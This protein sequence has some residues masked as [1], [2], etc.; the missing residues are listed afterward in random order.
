MLQRRGTGGHL[1]NHIITQ[2]CSFGF[3][4]DDQETVNRVDDGSFYI[5]NSI[6][7]GNGRD[8]ENDADGIDEEAIF[9]TAAWDNQVVDPLLVDPL[10]RVN[11][12]FRLQAGSPAASGNGATPPN[13]GFFD[14]SATCIGA[15]CGQTEWYEGWT[16]HASS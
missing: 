14:T 15:V 13:D 4:V 11:P 16:T 8:F 6:V 12:D 2:A 3:D 5:K 7:F 9:M 1:F 10:N